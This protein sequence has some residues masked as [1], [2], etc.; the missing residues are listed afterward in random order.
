MYETLKTLKSDIGMIE[1]TVN[2]PEDVQEEHTIDKTKVDRQEDNAEQKEEYIALVI[3]CMPI[4]HP[5]L[6]VACM[7]A[8]KNKAKA[9]LKH[10]TAPKLP[11]ALMFTMTGKSTPHIR[12][13][14]V[15]KGRVKVS[16]IINHTYVCITNSHKRKFAEV[17]EEEEETRCRNLGNCGS[18]G[19][20]PQK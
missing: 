18:E 19:L 14:L 13:P 20:K 5:K 10:T 7:N 9:K 17:K 16:P 11:S 4:Q 2:R 8:D 12:L 1:E 3:K 15:P 6:S